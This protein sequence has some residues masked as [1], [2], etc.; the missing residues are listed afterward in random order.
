MKT[1]KPTCARSYKKITQKQVSKNGK[2]EHYLAKL[3]A[4]ALC[5]RNIYCSSFEQ[6]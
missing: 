3:L 5:H 1:F 2:H 6:N 4:F